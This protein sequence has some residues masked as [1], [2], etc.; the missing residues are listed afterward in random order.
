M[1]L[2]LLSLFVRL[3]NKSL[4]DFS[5]VVSFPGALITSGVNT[6]IPAH[7]EKQSISKPK[8]RLM[9]SNSTVHTDRSLPENR[10]AERRTTAA[11]AGEW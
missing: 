7:K 2:L 10:E 1:T 5:F 11:T 9:Y 3:A 4:I 8:V 6:E